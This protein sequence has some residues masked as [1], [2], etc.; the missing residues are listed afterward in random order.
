MTQFFNHFQSLFALKIFVQ[1][2]QAQLMFEQGLAIILRA[3]HLN[4]Y[5]PNIT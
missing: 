4:I 3:L 1:Y 5:I 2:E